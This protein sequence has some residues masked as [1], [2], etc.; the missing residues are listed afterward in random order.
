MAF[1]RDTQYP[2]RTQAL[3][4]FPVRF[5][6]YKFGSRSKEVLPASGVDASPSGINSF[7]EHERPYLVPTEVAAGAARSGKLRSV[8]EVVDVSGPKGLDGAVAIHADIDYDLFQ[9]D[10]AAQLTTEGT[11][12]RV[13]PGVDES[14]RQAMEISESVEDFAKAVG[15]RLPRMVSTGTTPVQAMGP[16]VSYNQFEAL[17]WAVARD[18]GQSDYGLRL[19]NLARIVAHAHVWR[20]RNQAVRATPSMGRTK[21]QAIMSA[22]LPQIDSQRF[23]NDCWLYVGDETDPKYKA[24]LLM[25]V[26]GLQYYVDGAQQTVYSRLV[27]DPELVDQ[28]VT[29]VLRSG[30]MTYPTIASY[31]EVLQSPELCLAYYYA[32]AASLG[33]GVGATH[34]L[35]Q[36]I[37]A[38]HIYNDAAVLPYRSRH[39][40]LDAATY[41]LRTGGG[42]VSQVVGGCARLIYSAPVIATRYL[43][44]VGAVLGGFAR[45]VGISQP[46][47]VAQVVGAVSDA[48]TAREVSACV[49]S[50]VT[51]GYVALEW[52]DPFRPDPND[53]I[54][55]AISCYRQYLH[56]LGQARR[57]PAEALRGVFFDG[58]DMSNAIP[59]VAF[60]GSG[61]DR[62]KETLV[63]Q[64]AAGTALKCRA[65]PDTPA[66][67]GSNPA[68]LQLLRTWRAVVHWVRYNLV[69]T[70]EA[71]PARA[72]SP[73]PRV[74]TPVGPVLTFAHA[75]PPTDTLPERGRSPSVVSQTT[76]RPLVLDS[77]KVP[78]GPG[79]STASK[80]RPPGGITAATPSTRGTLPA[81]SGGGP[82]TPR[83]PAP[84]RGEAP[85]QSPTGSSQKGS[86]QSSDTVSVRGVGP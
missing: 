24:F 18:A 58:V 67:F 63:Y 70:E 16:G 11:S 82:T 52:L 36:T 33:I 66:L 57:A 31:R 22:E 47:V 44:G 30:Q 10:T 55:N 59:G 62:F 20:L 60:Q 34:V 26:Q 53:G 9:K 49:W 29:F 72:L 41:L 81:A 39:P 4:G 83:Q 75:V 79:S 84:V 45:G 40:R 77:G 74:D 3:A 35:L 46:D 69:A 80:A 51:G 37:L 8:A 7:I 61:E 17:R 14:K 76:V 12:F 2:W 19:H 25:G 54:V 65:E 86:P 42:T 27:S 71:T 1:V 56:L 5:A 78:S 50:C 6:E 64:L 73:P 48:N 23:L 21:F 68:A 28:N 13:S 38:P 43:A 32:Y 85:R 15:I